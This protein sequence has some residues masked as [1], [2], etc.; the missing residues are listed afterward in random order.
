MRSSLEKDCMNHQKSATFTH[1][2]LG[3]GTNLGNKRVNI[4]LALENIE[5]QIGNI[6]SQS[7]FY[8]SEPLGF[9]SDN[10]FL[11]CTVEIKTTLLPHELLA[12]TQALEKSMGRMKKT[13]SS[14]YSD[15]IIDIDILFFNSEI[16]NDAPKLVIPHP[17]MQERDF[18]LKPLAEIAP[19]FVHPVLNKTV[20]QLLG[21]L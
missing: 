11:N 16:V 14:G 6:V 2:Y 1:V 5:K 4:E 8:S 21:E 9:E 10:L 12:E 17:L 18:V 19:D 20:L 15:R 7:A 3:L 13:D